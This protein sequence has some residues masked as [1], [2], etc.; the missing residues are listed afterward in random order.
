V[1]YP[2]VGLREDTAF[3]LDSEWWDRPTYEPYPRRR[4]GLLGDA[5][6]DYAAEVYPQQLDPYWVSS[7]PEEE[8]AEEMALP[9]EEYQP[10]ELSE[11]EAIR[12]AIEES[13][14]LEL[15]QWTGLVAQL[16]ASAS[17]SRVAP[18]PP[19][20]K[21]WDYVVWESWLRAPPI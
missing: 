18:P 5:K 15:G 9:V 1:G 3:T 21:P 6:Y 20:P 7:P 13:E 2:S 14:L 16:A 19:A 12:R 4:S 10:P 8:E 11:E 17:T